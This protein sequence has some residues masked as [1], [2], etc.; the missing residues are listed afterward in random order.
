MTIFGWFK[1]KEPE[2]YE[3]VLESLALDIRKRQMRLSEIRLRERR[4]TLLITLYTLAIWAAYI[5]AWYAG[6]RP[7]KAFPIFIGPIIIQFSRR[8]AQTWY[9][10]IGNAEEKTLKELQ[11]QQRSKVEEFKKKMNYY[12]TKNLIERYDSPSAPNTPARPRP[13]APPG[14]RLQQGQMTLQRGVQGQ[15]NG[16]PQANR[17]Q[18][19][20]ATQGQQV[21]LSPPR[22][23]W[24]DKLADAL[25][26]DDELSDNPKNRYALICQKCFT[27]NG[28]VKEEL[29]EDTQFVCPKCG[30]FNPS[31][32][33]LKAGRGPTSPQQTHPDMQSQRRAG[34]RMSAP[35]HSTGPLLQVEASGLDRRRS[36]PA[37]NVSVIT[38]D[39]EDEQPRAETN[40][41]ARR[42]PFSPTVPL[43]EHEEEDENEE[44]E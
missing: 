16:F 10:R 23:Q 30:Q 28:L 44:H 4:T 19:A 18:P 38:S 14:A 12:S 31:M 9:E 2:N 29:W 21:P 32:R 15:P 42:S 33:A 40:A 37:P 20:L 24:Y 3:E 43:P 35:I 6:W 8:I 1:K 5:A 11:S 39:E 34:P 22:K 17:G 27:H 36:L 7:L 41:R 13:D 26:G 25:L